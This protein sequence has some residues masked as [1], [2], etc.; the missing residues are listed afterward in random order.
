[1]SVTKTTISPNDGYAY[2]FGYNDK[3]QSNAND[4]LI[5]MHRTTTENFS[6]GLNDY[7]DVG[8]LDTATNIFHVIGSTN[9]WNW[10]TGAMLQFLGTQDKI[11]YNKRNTNGKLVSAIYDISDNTTTEL[12]LPVY[13]ADKQGKYGYSVNFELLGL[14][15]PGY[16]YASNYDIADYDTIQDNYIKRIDLTT[17]EIVT[18]LTPFDKLKGDDTKLDYFAHLLPSPDGKQMC[19]YQRSIAYTGQSNQDLALGGFTTKIYIVNFETRELKDFSSGFTILS[20]FDWINIDKLFV[21]G[22][23]GGVRGVWHINVT[24]N[25]VQQKFNGLV[26]SDVHLNNWGDYNNG[27]LICDSYPD[28]SGNIKL[29]WLDMNTWTRSAVTTFFLPSN[30][31]GE[32]RVDLHARHSRNLTKIWVDTVVNGK[33]AIVQVTNF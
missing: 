15:R 16:G 25:T 31:V 27:K 5:L 29:D 11:L 9:A 14:L 2:W 10:Q 7:V 28:G 30:F 32:W 26:N 1:M 23:K 20:H 18:I 17:G 13:I 19:F 24:A 21:W 33:R 6:P 3:Y 12:P 4:T 22:E 8:Y